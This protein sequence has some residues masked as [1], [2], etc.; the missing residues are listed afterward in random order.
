MGG[1]HKD[2]GATKS[3][4]G[5]AIYKFLPCQGYQWE[6]YRVISRIVGAASRALPPTLRGTATDRLRS[7]E[8]LRSIPNTI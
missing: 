3:R 7:I 2:A 5:G 6:R 1:E 8:D 4:S